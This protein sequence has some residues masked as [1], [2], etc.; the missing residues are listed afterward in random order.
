MVFPWRFSLST[1][2][3][4][5]GIIFI[6]QIIKCMASYTF[7]LVGLLISFTYLYF[8]LWIYIWWSMAVSSKSR[9]RT[10]ST[11][12]VS[13]ISLQADLSHS[14]WAGDA[15]LNLFFHSFPHRTLSNLRTKTL[16]CSWVLIVTLFIDRVSIGLNLSIVMIPVCWINFAALINLTII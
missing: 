7:F 11:L 2:F 14:P 16:W 6:Q 4:L 10:I 15:L 12:Q 8:V 13:T 9:S 5:M 3:E 1:D